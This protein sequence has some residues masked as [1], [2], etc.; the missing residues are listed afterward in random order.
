MRVTRLIGCCVVLLL[1]VASLGAASSGVANAAMDRNK[2]AVRSLLQQK[3]DVNALQADGTTALH[4][5]VYWDDLE[6]A[7]LLIRAGANAKAANRDGATPLFLACV[8]GNAA[9]IEKL[10]KA[11]ADAN[12]PLTH[13]GDTALMVAARTGAPDAVKVLLDHGADPNTKE[14]SGGTTALMWA[15]EQEHPVVI[16]M[17]IAHG[18]AVN[19]RS[20]GTS[21]KAKYASREEMVEG[22]LQDLGDIPPTVGAT[23]GLTPL[24]FAARQGDQDSVRILLAAGADVNQFSAD[25]S[26][27]LETAIRNGHYDLAA[28]LL[29][30]GANPNHANAAG[31][32]PLYLAVHCRNLEKS[33]TIPWTTI[34]D[35]LDLIKK[36]LDAGA[37]PNARINANVPTRAPFGLETWL[38]QPGA[39]AF[40]RAAFNGDIT[41]MRLLLAHGADPSVTTNDHT[42]PLMALAGI[43]WIHSSSMV[44]PER[45]IIEAMNLLL[46]LGADV[47][48]VNDDGRTALHGAAYKG[49]NAAIQPL[50]DHGAKLDARDKRNY[51]ST[52]GTTP[53]DY[54]KGI[55]INSTAVVPQPQTEALL[56]QLMIARGI[57]TDTTSECSLRGNTCGEIDPK[58]IGTGGKPIQK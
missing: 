31:L 6:M 9:M 53:L 43:G 55:R 48:A 18:A 51:D 32:T 16:Q 42:T 33:P 19:A 12:A 25:G 26:S 13:Y 56:R 40:L 15:A 35:P 1:S 14:T 3:A 34:L 24:L 50:V 30:A 7:E 41:V 5:A 36:L 44:R 49:W 21:S 45:E 52:E 27:A 54:A 37:N 4:W 28:F 8:N 11:G 38:K 46:D 47:N 20:K 2:E 17:L 22:K 58:L 57:P 29:D 39:T 10:L 23:G